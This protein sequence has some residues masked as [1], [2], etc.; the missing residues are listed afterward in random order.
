[1]LNHPALHPNEAYV[2]PGLI[3]GSCQWQHDRKV[4]GTGRVVSRIP[5]TMQRELSMIDRIHSIPILT[6]T[7]NRR[8]PTVS[9]ISSLILVGIPIELPWWIRPSTTEQWP[10]PNLCEVNKTRWRTLPRAQVRAEP[11]RWSEAQW[12]RLI[13]YERSTTY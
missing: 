2:F 7:L 9:S 1:M 11:V 8:R 13:E 10:I 6:R 4:S 3:P 5:R 12:C